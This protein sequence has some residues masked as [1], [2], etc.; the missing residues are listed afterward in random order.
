MVE[1]KNKYALLAV[2]FIA[3]LLFPTLGLD[4][5]NDMVSR[6]V[7]L[8]LFAVSL[9]LLVGYTGLIS[10]GHA[11]WFGVGA[12]AFALLSTHYQVTDSFWI[13][14]PVA[15]IAAAVLSF[16]VGLFVLRTKGIYF[17]M[18]TLAFAQVFYF[19]VHDVPAIGGSTD[20]LNLYARPT[21][22]IGN[23][24]LLDL[25]NPLTMYYFIL[26]AL[27]FSVV[28][29]WFFLRSPLGRAV[30]GIKINE[31]RMLSIGFPVFRYKLI[32]FVIAS[33][34]ASLAGYLFAAQSYGVNPELLSW[35]KSAD[36]LLMLI[37]G[38]MGQFVGGMVGAFAFILL[39]D[40]FMTYT[41]WWQLWLGITIVLFV[42]FLPGGLASL[43][44][45]LKALVGKA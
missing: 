8:A 21:L 22:E 24:V 44:S 32:V 26:A 12:Y 31:H 36:V 39:K 6:I 16:I 2:M 42:L 25:E 43:P 34:F 41:D 38:G 10:F 27:F 20:G 30:Q 1:S 7:I 40:V 13:T 11:A 3:L 18:V 29:L 37:F 15:L 17:I 19:L 5:Y 45:R 35:H 33:V 14:L 23:W 9:D 4:F 28:L